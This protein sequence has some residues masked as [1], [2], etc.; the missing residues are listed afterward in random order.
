MSEEPVFVRQLGAIV[1]NNNQR[2]VAGDRAAI[3]DDVNGKL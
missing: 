2:D 1:D 3:M